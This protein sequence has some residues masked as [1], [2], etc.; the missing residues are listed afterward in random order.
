MRSSSRPSVSSPSRNFQ[1]IP[2]T[3]KNFFLHFIS[4]RPNVFLLDFQ[5]WFL[6]SECFSVGAWTEQSEFRT[7]VRHRKP[8]D[9]LYNKTQ[10]KCFEVNLKSCVTYHFHL[11]GMRM[12]ML[13]GIFKIIDL[14]R[15]VKNKSNAVV[16][17]RYL[18]K[19]WRK[20]IDE[21]SIETCLS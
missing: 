19:S 20:L 1:F 10:Q 7:Q 5:R 16:V 9:H 3:G 13:Y 11:L 12:K 6:F 15:F 17:I 4:S 8:C 14:P 21:L 2:L 18:L